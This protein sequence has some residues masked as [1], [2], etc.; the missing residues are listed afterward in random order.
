MCRARRA[1]AGTCLT[2]DAGVKYSVS[3][4]RTGPMSM[5]ITLGSVDVATVV[6]HLN[7]GGLLIQVPALP[8]DP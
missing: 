7:D 1:H 2:A 6:R 5:R 8:P 4:A 3:V